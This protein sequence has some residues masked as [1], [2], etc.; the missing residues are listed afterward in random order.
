MKKN[1][2]IYEAVYDGMF[3]CVREHKEDSDSFAS[4]L[5]RLEHGS[6][7][8]SYNRAK[9]IKSLRILLKRDIEYLKDA[10]K[11]LK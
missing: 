2:V 11:M 4:A 1:R 3:T 7:F 5:Q 10:L 6:E 9:I 8:F